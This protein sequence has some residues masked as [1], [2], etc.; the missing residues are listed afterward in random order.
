MSVFSEI[1][2]ALAL[3]MRGMPLPEQAHSPETLEVV[4]AHGGTAAGAGQ[5]LRAL[6]VADDAADL[7]G[8]DPIVFGAIPRYKGQFSD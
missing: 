5:D 6:S 4:T 2:A 1:A 8:L 7:G 3:R